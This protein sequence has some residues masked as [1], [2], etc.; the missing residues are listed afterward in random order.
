MNIQNNYKLNNHFKNIYDSFA[1]NE[2]IWLKNNQLEVNILCRLD[3]LISYITA[4]FSAIWMSL[5]SNQSA[6]MIFVVMPK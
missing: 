1:N 2:F 4:I 3:S 6:A 5:L